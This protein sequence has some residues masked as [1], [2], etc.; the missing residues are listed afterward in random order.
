VDRGVAISIPDG[1]LRFGPHWPNNPDAEIDH[2]VEAIGGALRE[3]G[4][5]RWPAA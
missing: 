5:P 3:L 4:L 2:T 1:Q